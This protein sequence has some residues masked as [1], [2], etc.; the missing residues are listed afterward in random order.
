MSGQ[1]G[2]TRRSLVVGVDLTPPPGSELR[3]AASGASLGH[4]EVYGPAWS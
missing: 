2:G 4:D 3:T 1:V